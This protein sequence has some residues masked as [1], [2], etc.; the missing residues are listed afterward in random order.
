[1]YTLNDALYL[2]ELAYVDS[3]DAVK[4]GLDSTEDTSFE[5][6]Y[7]TVN[8]KPERSQSYKVLNNWST[9][10]YKTLVATDRTSLYLS[11]PSQSRWST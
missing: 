7:C 8:G 2:S 11:W 6:I 10:E 9:M 4:D 1:M 3:I 5:L